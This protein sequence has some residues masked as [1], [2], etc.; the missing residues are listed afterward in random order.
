MSHRLNRRFRAHSRVGALVALTVA[1]TPA[2]AATARAASPVALGTAQSFAVLA[3]STITN[4]GA[5][6][7]FGDI[8]LCCSGLAT[9]GFGPG[10]DQ[11]TQPAG[12]L[13]IGPGSVAATAQ[14]DLDVAYA[15]ASGQAVSNTVPVDLSLSGT[16]ANPL[17]PGVYESTAQGAFQINTGLTLDF[18]GDPNAVFIFRATTLTTA[19][20][21]PGSVTIVNGGSTASACNIFWRLSDPTQGV[22]LGAGSAFK[23]TTM[24][25]GA[26]VLGRGATV[27]GRILT[28]RDKAVNLD[29]NTIMRPA[30]ATPDAGGGDEGG[31]STTPIPPAATPT[32]PASTPAP[33]ASAP[34]AATPI[35]PPQSGQPGGTARLWGPRGTVS[36]P[37]RVLVTGRAIQ[38][39]TFFVDGRPLGTVHRRPGRRLTITIPDGQRSGLHRVTVRVRF[40]PQ[41]GSRSTTRQ[42][43]FRRSSGR[44]AAPSFTG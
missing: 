1:L 22:T 41:S 7:I 23:G 43:T 19:A 20:S 38:S 36:G 27:E 13:Y 28:R 26:S 9:T 33:P 31:G 42:L 4:T 5:T 3:G 25:L 18:Q 21:A 32:P 11:V 40:T 34:T 39:V 2:L 24:S 15:N 44:T 6:T 29:T 8:G 35:A 30:C 37:F 17:L 14:A 10:A 12:A 16:P